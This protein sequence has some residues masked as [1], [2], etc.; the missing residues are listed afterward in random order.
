MK[1]K[2]LAVFL[3]VVLVWQLIAAS[4][5][6]AKASSVAPQESIVMRAMQKELD[7]SFAQLKTAGEAPLY[8]LGYRIYDTQSLNMTAEYGALDAVPYLK[9]SR[10][11]GIN[12]RVGSPHLDNTHKIRDQ[13][14]VNP[15]SF[16]SITPA[17]IPIED[18]EMA[19]RA[20]I[21]AKTDGAFRNAQ[22]R[23]TVVK[24]N[25]DTKAAEEDKADDFSQ[26]KPCVY[27]GPPLNLVADGQAWESRL[28]RLS[29]IYCQYA[30]ILDSRVEFI[31][32]K[33]RRYL[34]TSEGTRVQDE[35]VHYRLSTTAEALADDGMRVWLYDGVEADLATRIAY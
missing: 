26:E 25:Q 6:W 19:I 15:D 17:F 35:S 1:E 24:T 5:V 30:D 11:L 4:G 18:D 10:Y 27:T 16:R 33:T 9:H 23:F 31:A 28:R 2:R 13:N 12:L 14:R 29:A 8:F 20:A 21:W 34:V 7:R 32:T 3:V 22:K